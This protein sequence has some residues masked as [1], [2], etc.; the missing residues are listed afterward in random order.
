MFELVH[1]KINGIIPTIIMKTRGLI[2]KR[3]NNVYLFWESF[4]YIGLLSVV[5]ISSLKK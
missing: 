1:V 5:I 3:I 2:F 4:T